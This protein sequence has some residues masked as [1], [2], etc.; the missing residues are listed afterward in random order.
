MAAPVTDQPTKETRLSPFIH[1]RLRDF[2]PFAH[3]LGGQP[4]SLS[5]PVEMALNMMRRAYPRN[6]LQRKRQVLPSPAS[7]LVKDVRH[8]AVAMIIEQTVDLRNEIWLGL[9]NL[10]NRHGAVEHEA[11]HRTAAQ[12]NVYGDF[13]RLQEGYI[14]DQ[15]PKH[16]LAFTGVDLGVIP[17]LGKVFC[18]RNHLLAGLFIGLPAPLL[19]LPLALFLSCGVST[20]LLIPL[21]LQRI[22]YESVIGVHF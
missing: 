5:Q 10:G 17:D 4:T 12:A 21:R 19:P 18:E 8:F 1:G 14:F 11:A 22:G 7:L 20:Q 15:Q 2:Q 13:I 6:F 3:L 9:A 16:P